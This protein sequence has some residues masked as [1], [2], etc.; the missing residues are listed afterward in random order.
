MLLYFWVL[1][2]LI[3]MSIFF[4]SF[5]LVKLAEILLA[6]CRHEWDKILIICL[7]QTYFV[8]SWCTSWDA[9]IPSVAKLLQ[10][11]MDCMKIL[12][13]PPRCQM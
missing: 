12:D 9:V 2:Q 6:P 8:V 1:L 7:L 10:R 3:Q 11:T 13:I 5:P 4:K